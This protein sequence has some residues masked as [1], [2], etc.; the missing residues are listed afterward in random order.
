MD[1]V[2]M[3][4]D[5][6]SIITFILSFSISLLFRL[7]NLIHPKFKKRLEKGVRKL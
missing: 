4:K 6:K 5:N 3:K 1:K 2:N 7:W